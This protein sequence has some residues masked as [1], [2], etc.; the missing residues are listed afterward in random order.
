MTNATSGGLRLQCMMHRNS[1][2]PT[3]VYI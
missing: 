3:C 2:I 1:H